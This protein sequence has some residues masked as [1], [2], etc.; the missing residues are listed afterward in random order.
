MMMTR[1]A[2]ADA[3]SEAAA[4]A[5]E[6]ALNGLGHGAIVAGGEDVRRVVAREGLAHGVSAWPEGDIVVH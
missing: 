2:A 4:A 5:A 6:V 1:A 3:D